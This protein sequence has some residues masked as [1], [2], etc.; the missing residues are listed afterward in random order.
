MA[1]R[2]R[3]HHADGQ[4]VQRSIGPQVLTAVRGRPRHGEAGAEGARVQVAQIHRHVRKRFDD[5]VGQQDV[6]VHHASRAAIVE[7]ADF[8][9]SQV[10][11]PERDVV[12]VHRGA[13]VVRAEMQL[14]VPGPGARA[15]RSGGGHRQGTTAERLAVD[16]AGERAGRRAG[17]GHR[18]GDVVPCRPIPGSPGAGRGHLVA[19][20]IGAGG[21]RELDPAVGQHIHAPA[22]RLVGVVVAPALVDQATADGT[23]PR[24]AGHGPAALARLVDRVRVGPAGRAAG[25]SKGGCGADG[26]AELAGRRGDGVVYRVIGLV[27]APLVVVLHVAPAQDLSGVERIRALQ[28]A[29]QGLRGRE[30]ER[31]VQRPPGGAVV[32]VGY[33][34]ARQLA[35]PDAEVVQVHGAAAARRAH[36][37]LA[38][39]G[40]AVRADDLVG[41][42]RDSAAG[43]GH[44]V[45]V[46]LVGILG[47]ADAVHREGD[48]VPRRTVPRPGMRGRDLLAGA[49]VVLRQREFELAVRQHPDLPPRRV[50]RIVRPAALVAQ[51]AADGAGTGPKGEAPTAQVGLKKRIGVGAVRGGIGGAVAVVER[52]Q[53]IAELAADRGQRQVGVVRRFMVVPLAVVLHVPAKQHLAG[54]EGVYHFQVVR[55]GRRGGQGQCIQC[56]Q[57]Q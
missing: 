33:F 1:P 13:A 57:R 14:A 10:A 47:R 18:E 39:P 29:P 26:A 21:H 3:K 7:V 54:V 23:G 6:V 17:A 40:A 24:P 5:G 49:G 34:S 11:A 32:Q 44:A 50:V 52:A 8:A 36:P 15:E 45:E 38:E 28:A 51:T 46:T 9:G 22:R 19:H 43:R 2:R 37:E 4:R 27:L 41:G 42:D 12:Q 31:R 56:P 48:V 35:R 55:Q 53:G 30:G 20:G 25:R 16:V